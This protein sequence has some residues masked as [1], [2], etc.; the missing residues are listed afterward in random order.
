MKCNN[1]VKC[2]VGDCKYNCQGCECS[3]EMI[4]VSRGQDLT[5]SQKPLESPHFCKT[6]EKKDK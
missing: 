1:G 4:E 2:N 6:Y 3:K 5:S